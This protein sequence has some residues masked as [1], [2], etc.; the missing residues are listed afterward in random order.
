[1]TR[2]S[3]VQSRAGSRQGDAVLARSLTELLQALVRIPSRAGEDSCAAALDHVATWLDAHG[4]PSQRLLADGAPVGLCSPLDGLD[5]PLVL[6]ATIDTAGFGDVSSWR[7]D[8]VSGAI[9]D[10]WLYG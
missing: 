5:H 6:D 9:V 7:H 4:V 1:M 3:W 10:G 2:A 8:P